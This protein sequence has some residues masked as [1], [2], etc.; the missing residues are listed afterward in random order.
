MQKAII[1]ARVHTG[2]EILTD[3]VII[4]ENGII[5][6]VRNETPDEA[7]I[8]DLKD[9]NIAAGFIDIQLNGGE[10]FHFT[11]SP[12]EET[13]RDMYESSLKAGATHIL[14][15]LITSSKENILKGIEAV[16][17]YR[18]KHNNGVMG[19]HLEG[20]YINP[21][22]RGAHAMQHIRV[23]SN[24]ELEEIIKYGRDVIKIITIAPECLPEEQVDM[25]QESGIRISI[26]HS[27]ISYQQAQYYFSKGIRLV[28]HLFNAMSPFGHREPGLVGAALENEQVYTP[29]ILDGTHC[30]YAAAH[31]AYRLK[32]GKM[33][34]ITDALFLGK[35]V[36]SFKWEG[37]DVSLVNG[38]YRTQEGN[39]SGSSV[40]MAE[41]VRNAI[42]H[43]K[44]SVNEAIQMATSTVAAAIGME[45][46][47]GKIA[48][49]FPAQFVKFNN[50]LSLIEPFIV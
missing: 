44:V 18:L 8:V 40:S 41:V 47:V 7:I 36:R 43:L 38:F 30:D 31:L 46:Q 19:M 49:G 1:N 26:G 42:L 33:L 20:P 45:N 10:K 22:K 28:T 21:L 24:A 29:I 6:S 27:N 11:Q 2:T 16:R 4:V 37:I 39:L 34:L 14:P 23:P 48:A 5:Q 35:K 3:K 13:I 17:N 9:Q 15:C 12:T 25:L 50:D 32:K